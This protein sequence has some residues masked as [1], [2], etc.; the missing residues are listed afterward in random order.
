MHR[1]LIL[2]IKNALEMH[3]LTVNEKSVRKLAL[4]WGV[5]PVL[6]EEVPSTDVLFYTAQKSAKKALKLEKGDR[7]IITGGVING[8]S[9]N[10]NLLKIET[11]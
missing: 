3:G 10:T 11:I 9:G 1:L 8:Q 6:C 7:I 4:S 5:I 2:N